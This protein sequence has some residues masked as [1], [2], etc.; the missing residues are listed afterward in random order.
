[1]KTDDGRD[2]N[3]VRDSVPIR[4]SALSWTRSATRPTE[5]RWRI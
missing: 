3:D 2:H 1:M 5:P 4:I